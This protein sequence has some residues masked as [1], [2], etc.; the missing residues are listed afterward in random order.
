MDIK[1]YTG[2]F[3]DG[4]FIDEKRKEKNMELFL[5][6]CEISP[7][8]PI[9]RKILSKDNALR[10]KLCLTGVKW[11]KVDDK[12]NKKIPW[13]EYDDGEILDLKIDDNKVFLLIEWTNFPP[14]ARVTDTGTIEIEAEKIYWENIPD[15]SDGY[16]KEN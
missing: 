5:R 4:G 10:G 9:D 16:F 6:S 14:K 12:E 15:L 1:K 8:D 7:D 11:I 3:H 2:Y 13:K